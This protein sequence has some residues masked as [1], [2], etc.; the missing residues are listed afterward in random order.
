MNPPTIHLPIVPRG[1]WVATKKAVA[2]AL[3]A[4]KKNLTK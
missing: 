3:A 4:A 2:A 1:G